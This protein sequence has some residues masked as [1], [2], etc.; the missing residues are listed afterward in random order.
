MVY[1]VIAW[2]LK[3]FEKLVFANHRFADLSPAIIN[4]KIIVYVSTN[5]LK[6]AVLCT[7]ADNPL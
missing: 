5:D 7:K 2:T 4:L 1:V 3:P 6:W